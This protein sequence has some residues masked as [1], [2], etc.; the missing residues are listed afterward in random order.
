[1]KW[2]DIEWIYRAFNELKESLL[3]AQPYG[4][5]MRAVEMVEKAREEAGGAL[6]F[7]DVEDDILSEEAKNKMKREYLEKRL[8]NH[9]DYCKACPNAWHCGSTNGGVGLGFE[10]M[11]QKNICDNTCK[12]VME[13]LGLSDTLMNIAVVEITLNKLREEKR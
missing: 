11:I 6:L 3:V 5:T 10:G 1:M 12:A 2:S 8:Q 4:I 9:H 13:R 7:A